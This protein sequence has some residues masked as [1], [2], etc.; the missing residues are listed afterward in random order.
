MRLY[1]TLMKLSRMMIPMQINLVKLQTLKMM[2][3]QQALQNI[4]NAFD[5]F[6]YCLY[7]CD[8]STPNCA[9]TCKLREKWKIPPFGNKYP[10]G[11]NANARV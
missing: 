9:N 7:V 10:Q 6:I 5:A 1:F 8:L 2:N 11:E 3:F 4:N